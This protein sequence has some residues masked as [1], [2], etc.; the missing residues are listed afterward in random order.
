[1]PR[2]RRVV[3]GV[4]AFF[5]LI[6]PYELLIRPGWEQWHHPAFLFVAAISLGA[7]SVSAF[8]AFAAVAGLEQCMRFDLGS[9]TLTYRRSAPIVPAAS[10][11][12]P[13]E[14]IERVATVVHTWSDGPD[15]YSVAVVVSGRTLTTSSTDSRAEADRYVDRINQVLAQRHE[16][17]T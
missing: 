2:G 11:T 13:F 6:A 9:R 10:R 16:G 12:W 17:G 15:S 14:A 1:M 4:L 3:F 8:L 5:P 7:V